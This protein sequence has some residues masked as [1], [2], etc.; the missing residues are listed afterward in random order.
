MRV[1]AEDLQRSLGDWRPVMAVV[2]LTEPKMRGRHASVDEEGSL[3]HI[4]S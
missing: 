4:P 2:N 3:F 1:G